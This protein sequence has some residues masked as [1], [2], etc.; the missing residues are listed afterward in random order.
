MIF[1]AFLGFNFLQDQQVSDRRTHVCWKCRSL[2][3]RPSRCL[4]IFRLSAGESQDVDTMIRCLIS[5]RIFSKESQSTQKPWDF[6][7]KIE[8]SCQWM[9]AGFLIFS[10]SLTFTANLRVILCYGRGWAVVLGFQQTD[11]LSRIW[12][13]KTFS[14]FLAGK[15]QY[16]SS[17]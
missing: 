12:L 11:P 7:K 16:S 17:I 14:I 13:W 15:C 10:I 3:L 6:L 1:W 9:I 2:S 5:D 4:N 8:W